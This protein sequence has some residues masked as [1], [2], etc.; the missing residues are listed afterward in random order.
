MDDVLNDDE[1]ET[2]RKGAMGAGLLV[3]ASDPGFF[4]TFKEAT[5]LA[6][7]VA[8]CARGLRERDSAARRRR[9]RHWFRCHP[10]S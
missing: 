7:H 6:K 5:T 3:S 10:C 4:D 8:G 9:A 2:L 1:I